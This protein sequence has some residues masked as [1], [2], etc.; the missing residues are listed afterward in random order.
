MM[1]LKPFQIKRVV[2][3]DYGVKIDVK[4]RLRHLVEA[5]HIYCLIARKHT[6]YSLAEIGKVINRDHACVLHSIRRAN[7]FLIYDRK[8]SP[9]NPDFYDK[10]YN[11]ED[12]I[13]TLRAN[14][15]EK[16]LGRE[17]KLQNAVMQYFKMQHPNEFV[18]H[19]PNEGKRSPFERFKFKYLGG[20]AGVPDILCF[21]PRGGYCGLAIELK[22]GY[23]KPTE[24]QTECLEKLEDS[25]WNVHWCNSFDKAKEIIDEYFKY[26]IDLNV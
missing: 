22:V 9:M 21:S 2:E 8:G 7:E 6:E 19:V 25:N 12:K 15:F 3:R 4:S 14:G 23:N 26:R 20:K 24:S 11:L 18:I 13:L 1:K 17:D 10:F 5:R 16:Y